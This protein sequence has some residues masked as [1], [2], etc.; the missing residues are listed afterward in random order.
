MCPTQ[1]SLSVPRFPVWEGLTMPPLSVLAVQ[2]I[3]SFGAGTVA[4]NDYAKP[5][6]QHGLSSEDNG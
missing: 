3:T 5:L 2:N 6:F 4:F 1:I